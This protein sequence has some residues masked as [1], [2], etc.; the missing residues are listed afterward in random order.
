[1][2][3]CKELGLCK[4]LG[5][6]NFSQQSLLNLI[7]FVKHP[8]TVNQVE[9]HCYLT[10]NKMHQF[11]KRFK[12]VM[13]AHCPLARGGKDQ[14]A[15]LGDKVDIFGETVLKALSEKY[16]KTPA[17]LLLNYQIIRGVAVVPKTEKLDHLRDNFNV[18]DFEL[19]E[20]DVQ[21]LEALDQGGKVRVYQPKQLP[22]WKGLD[23]LI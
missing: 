12:I 19:L 1:M 21:L 11:L 6:S 5:V 20:D 16:S 23:P 17:Q 8:P 14:K 4:S 7:P 15:V 3:E 18:T 13:S 2:E 22:Q 9:S 10:R